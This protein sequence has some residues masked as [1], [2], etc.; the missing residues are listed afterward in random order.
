MGYFS[1]WTDPCNHRYNQEQ[2]YFISTDVS[3]HWP[4]II[5]PPWPPHIPWAL[6][7]RAVFCL[8]NFVVSECYVN[9]V[10]YV[11]PFQ[12]G[13]FTHSTMPVGCLPGA[14]G[15][16]VFPFRC[17]VGFC[18]GPCCIFNVLWDILV[19]PSFWLLQTKLSGRDVCVQL[20]IWAYVFISLGYIPRS[21]FASNCWVMS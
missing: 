8:Y 20:F 14:V 11:W 2:N 16:V 13:L 7:T 21:A 10:I 18:R 9:E 1:T 4:F 3:S 5:R 19:V 15:I 17:G 12:I 6:A